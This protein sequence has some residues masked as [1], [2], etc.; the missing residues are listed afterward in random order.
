VTDGTKSTNK[1][2]IVHTKHREVCSVFKLLTLSVGFLRIL[3]YM[4]HTKQ[5]A[6]KNR[7][8]RR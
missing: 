7:L 3:Q 6:H 2:Q 5:V 8:P 1:V 4:C